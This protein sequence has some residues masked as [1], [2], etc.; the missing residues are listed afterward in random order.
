MRL[1]GVCIFCCLSVAPLWAK[2]PKTKPRDRPISSPDPTFFDG[3]Y[4]PKRPFYVYALPHDQIGP[5]DLPAA[6]WEEYKDRVLA[7]DEDETC[8]RMFPL[9]ENT[10]SAIWVAML[11][12]WT[13]AGRWLISTEEDR[14]QLVDELLLL[15]MPLVPLVATKGDTTQLH[16]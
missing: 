10:W 6:A 9:S 4:H 2:S 7:C 16:R 3:I 14:Q 11:S 15:A 1:V 13:P 5:Q 12:K 8:W